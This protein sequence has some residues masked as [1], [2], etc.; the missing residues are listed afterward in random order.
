[1]YGG[2]IT[3]NWDRR[4]NSIYLITFIIPGLLNNMNLAPQFKSPDP[5]KFDYAAYINYIDTKLPV[6][7]P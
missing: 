1:M 6:E 5:A 2:H 3:D 7:S 4:T